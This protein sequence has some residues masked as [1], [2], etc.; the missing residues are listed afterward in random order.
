MSEAARLNHQLDRRASGED[1]AM[2]RLPSDF[3]L[4]PTLELQ[5]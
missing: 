4:D 1:H 3:F 2:T 5:T